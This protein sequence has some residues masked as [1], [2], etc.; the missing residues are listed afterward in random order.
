MHR[1]PRPALAAASCLVSTLLAQVPDPVGR[2][3][4]AAQPLSTVAVLTVPAIDRVTIAAEDV[5]RRRN[6]APARYAI[7]FAVTASPATHG[8]WEQ[9]DG[10]WSLWRLRI[11]APNSSHINLGFA[12]FALPAGGRLQLYSSNYQDIVRPFDQND[13]SPTGQLWSPV[14]WTDEITAEIYVPT[15]LRPQVVADL[16]HVGSGYRFFGAGAEASGIDGSGTCNIDVNCPLGTGWTNQIKSVAAISTGGSLFCSGA[17]IN[18]TA[19]DGR[20]YFLTANH[21][22]VN[23]GAAPSLVCYWN[24]YQNTS[25]GGGVAT[26]TKPA[27]TMF[28][29]MA[30]DIGYTLQVFPNHPRALLTMERAGDRFRRDPPPGANFTVECWYLRAVRYRPDD[31]VARGLYAQ[32]LG[33]RKRIPEAVRQLDQAAEI[34]KDNA[35]SLFSIGLVFVELGLHDKA[36]PLAHRV[37]AMGYPR[38]ELINALKAAGRWSEPSAAAAAAPA[39]A[40]S[41]APSNPPT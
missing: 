20:N 38:Q 11:Q 28:G 4:P 17:M 37:Q 36:L 21:C 41:S 22:G 25:C 39:S 13:H 40:A 10:T 30:Q 6:G 31:T 29:L 18:N 2:I 8:T 5:D 35:L 7:P 19:Q 3:H 14:V 34:A 9:L 15:L 16:V 26:L 33:R 23:A 32:F 12:A 24:Y 27:T 1:S